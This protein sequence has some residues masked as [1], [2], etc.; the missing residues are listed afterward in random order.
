MRRAVAAAAGMI[1]RYSADHPG[2]KW[3]RYTLYQGFSRKEHVL[4]V[5]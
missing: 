5:D 1:G 2:L 4:Y 3:I